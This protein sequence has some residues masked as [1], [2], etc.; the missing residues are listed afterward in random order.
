MELKKNIQWEASCTLRRRTLRECIFF[1]GDVRNACK[2]VEDIF[3]I[4]YGLVIFF[5][6]CCI[7]SLISVISL[8]KKLDL[9]MLL[10]SMLRDKMN[11]EVRSKNVRKR[12]EK[13]DAL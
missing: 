8:S 12:L 1:S 9:M 11:G 5:Y 13:L 7:I 4:C 2:T 6:V 3:N 10:C